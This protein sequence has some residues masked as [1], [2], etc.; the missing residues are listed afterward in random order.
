ML[1]KTIS[2]PRILGKYL[3]SY[4][5]QFQIMIQVKYLV[6]NPQTCHMYFHHWII[7]MILVKL[8]HIYEVK[9]CEEHQIIFQVQ[10]FQYD[11][12]WHHKLI[13]VRL[14]EK[15]IQTYQQENHQ[16]IV[17]MKLSLY[18]HI[19]QIRIDQSIVQIVFLSLKPSSVTSSIPSLITSTKPSLTTR[20]KP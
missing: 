13:Q 3:N 2:N 4:H 10:C 19:H 20:N 6:T 15:N 9:L 1:C 8:Y 11:E 18:Y 5:Y 14:I 7:L 12:S 17:L 16:S